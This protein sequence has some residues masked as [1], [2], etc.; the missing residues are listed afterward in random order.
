MTSSILKYQTKYPSIITDTDI[1]LKNDNRDQD[2]INISL[3]ALIISSLE[4]LS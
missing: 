2:L 3:D 1:A 4:T